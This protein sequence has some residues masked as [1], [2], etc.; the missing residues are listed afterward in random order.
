MN[1]LSI[2]NSFSQNAHT[3]L[4][5]MM[6]ADGCDDFMLCNLYIPACSL[7]T[8]WQNMKNEREVY[9][10]QIYLPGE[11]VMNTANEVALFEPLEDEEW[12]VV[13]LQQASSLSGVE[14][15]WS[16][17]IE[18]LTAYVRMTAPKAKVFIHQTWAYDKSTLNEGFS[19]YSNS[20]DI[21]FDCIN[22]AVEIAVI[23]AD[24]DGVIPSGLAFQF[25]R[26]TKLK[27]MLT[28]PDGYHA[29]ILGCYLAGAC[30]YETITGK[31][32]LDNSYRIE[33]VP[34]EYAKLLAVCAH[35]A[36]E[37]YNRK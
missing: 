9:D 10:Y 18:E 36:V 14:E 16:P 29:N 27:D 34:D 19:K 24:V 3:H 11:T 15:S 26:Q 35:T 6:K 20:T 23:N 33:G 1:V 12:D 25:A 4:P 21:M 28:A 22:R 31:S 2:G 30:F 32:I 13:T 37:K 8:H 17:Y 7:E 5:A